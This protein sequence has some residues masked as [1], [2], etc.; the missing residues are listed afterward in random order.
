MRALGTPDRGD[1]AARWIS[2]ANPTW[3][4]MLRDTIAPTMLQA[5]IRQNVVPSE[6]RGVL[7]I[8]LLPGNQ[9]DPLV[10]QVAAAGERSA[11][12]L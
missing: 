9:L 6:A 3:N 8:R 4:A 5:G 10:A 2:D 1:H 11:G 12:A 7:N